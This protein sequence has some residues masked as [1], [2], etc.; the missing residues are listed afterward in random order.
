MT[1]D[2]KH[3]ESCLDEIDL[4]LFR[5]AEHDAC[6]RFH[7][8]SQLTAVVLLLVRCS[9]L[10]RALLTLF[11]SGEV[12]A[13]QVVLRAF[14][15]SWYL[16]HYLRFGENSDK[17]ARWLAG[18]NDSWS[19]DLR[20][21]KNFAKERGIPEPTIGKDYGRLSEVAHPKS[22]AENSVVLCGTRLGIAGADKE[23]V[24]EHNNEEARFPDALY[25]VV[26][27][28]VDQDRKFIP[29]HVKATDVPQSWK[30]CDGDKRLE[31]AGPVAELPQ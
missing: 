13:F 7:K 17:A 14:E 22:A 10:L 8:D 20:A 12:D 26:W 3:I 5:I 15:E 18:E 16:A 25:R 11:Q 30:F 4:N 27:L 21:L 28:M 6:Q 24:E 31:N 9:S 23:L 2:H 1:L 29:L 19:A